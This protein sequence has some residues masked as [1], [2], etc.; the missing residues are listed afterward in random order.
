MANQKNFTLGL[1]TVEAEENSEGVVR[2][3][4]GKKRKDGAR[5]EIQTMVKAHKKE[6]QLRVL[7]Q[8]NCRSVYNKV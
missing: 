6:G 8:V 1:E 5:N 3:N 2:D 4:A 7:L